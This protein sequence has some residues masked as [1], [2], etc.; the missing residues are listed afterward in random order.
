MKKKNNEKGITLIVLIITI[1]ALTILSTSII[2]NTKSLVNSK[3]IT[4]LTNDINNLQQKVSDFYNEYGELPADIEYTNLSRI[5]E[6][7]NDKEKNSKFY[8]ID[9]QAMR[10]I[11]L[12]YGRDYE[13]VKN[14][15]TETANQ[16]YDIYIINETTHNI[17]YMEGINNTN[18]RENRT[19]YTI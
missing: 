2:L 7:L 1:I 14:T 4:N 13:H 8:V 17:Y 15:N 19:Y 11:S 5:A 12:N 16:Y 3:N 6:V 18:N 9:L 10:G